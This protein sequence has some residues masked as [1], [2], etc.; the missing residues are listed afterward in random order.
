VSGIP[1]PTL[2]EQNIVVGVDQE[3]A[4]QE[5]HEGWIKFRKNVTNAGDGEDTVYGEQAL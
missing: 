3:W 1:S 5:K 2:G 4:S